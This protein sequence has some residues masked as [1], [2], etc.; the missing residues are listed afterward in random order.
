M[1]S[2]APDMIKEPINLFGIVGSKSPN[3]SGV[4]YKGRGRTTCIHFLGNSFQQVVDKKHVVASA[5]PPQV[6]IPDVIALPCF[7]R[8]IGKRRIPQAVRRQP[9]SWNGWALSATSYIEP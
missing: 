4:I 5:R 8:M 3:K 1:R 9:G 6:H 2:G 7:D